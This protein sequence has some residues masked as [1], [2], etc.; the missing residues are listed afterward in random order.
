VE[1]AKRE[2]GQWVSVDGNI[3]RFQ[4]KGDVDPLENA[5]APVCT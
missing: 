3:Q 2:T 1:F 5:K 4:L